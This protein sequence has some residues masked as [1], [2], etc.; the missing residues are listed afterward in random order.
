MIKTFSLDETES[1]PSSLF[2]SDGII[3]MVLFEHKQAV[4]VKMWR[5]WDMH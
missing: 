2:A 1:A 4:G 5:Y 3:I